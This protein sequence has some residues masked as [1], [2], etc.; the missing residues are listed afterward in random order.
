LQ[1]LGSK[2]F[3][4]SKTKIQKLKPSIQANSKHSKV[5]GLDLTREDFFFQEPLL[6][7]SDLK[8]SSSKPESKKKA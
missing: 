8:V 5:V 4:P 1:A 7:Q 6:Q 3:G 2:E